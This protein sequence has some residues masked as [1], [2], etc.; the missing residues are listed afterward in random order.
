MPPKEFSEVV[1]PTEIL[2]TTEVID[3]FKHFTSVPIPGG[4]KFSVLPRMKDDLPLQSCYMGSAGSNSSEHPWKKGVMTF[5]VNKAIMLCGVKIATDSV[6]SRPTCHVSLSIAQR[7]EKM[8]QI[9]DKYF[10]VKTHWPCGEVDVFFNRP[11]RLSHNTCYTIETETSTTDCRNPVVWSKS[12][13]ESSRQST[14]CKSEACIV[15]GHC[16]G[17]YTECIPR[18]VPYKGEILKLLFKG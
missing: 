12:L 3:V 5:T 7:G 17:L 4:P 10:T 1:L 11:C 15:S 18:H 6:Y 16:S 14:S 8:R 9:K 2:L 13:Q